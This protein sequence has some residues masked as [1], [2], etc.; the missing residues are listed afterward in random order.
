[1][2][3]AELIQALHALDC[4]DDTVVVVDSYD[5]SGE[6]R[7]S[8]PQH[9]HLIDIKYSFQTPGGYIGKAIRL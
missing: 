8:N 6:Q 2:T 7:Y 9:P 1:M 3:K 5:G 4:S